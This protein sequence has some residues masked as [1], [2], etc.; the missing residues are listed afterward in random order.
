MKTPLDRLQSDM[1]E[2]KER[3]GRIEAENTRL[4]ELLTALAPAQLRRAV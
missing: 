1:D 3:L 2:A 4:V